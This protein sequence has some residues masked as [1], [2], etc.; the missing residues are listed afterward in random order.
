MFDGVNLYKP[1]KII[2]LSE[3]SD[4]SE[5][6]GIMK[7]MGA[8]SYAYGIGY[9]PDDELR[10][11][12]VK[13]GRS[14]PDHDRQNDI[15]GERL[16]RQVAH[17]SGWPSTKISSHGQDYVNGL[18]EAIKL[19]KLPPRCLKKD[20][21]IIGIW[22]CHPNFRTCKVVATEL[23]QSRWLEAHLCKLYK[24]DFNDTLPLLNKV[25]PATSKILE[26]SKIMIQKDS[27][28]T[29][30]GLFKFN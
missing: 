14:S 21:T 8:R 22:N 2:R 15:H 12:F 25:D 17:L 6:Y 28:D 9:Q 29:N 20:N 1:D 13:I 24:N 4:S 5:I 18:E 11:I 10:I 26:Q 23:E 3:L 19:D 30:A 16:V 7:K 27:I